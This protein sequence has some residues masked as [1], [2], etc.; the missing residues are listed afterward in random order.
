VKQLNQLQLE[1]VRSAWD[2]L[3]PG[4][5][6]F[7]STCSPHPSETTGIIEKS[8][9]D[10]GPSAQLVDATALLQKVSP[11]LRLT[12]GRKTVQLWPHRDDTDAMFMAIIR[13]SVS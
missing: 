13:K 1:L 10:L 6:L 4:G 5:Y 8:L 2:A 9:R 7:Y 11:T 12:Q 3:E